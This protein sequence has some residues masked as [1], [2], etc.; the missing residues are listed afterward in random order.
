M[1]RSE[2]PDRRREP[3]RF[4]SFRLIGSTKGLA[5]VL[6]V[7]V[8]LVLISGGFALFAHAALW[9]PLTIGGLAG[10]LFLDL[11]YFNP[12]FVFIGVVNAAFLWALVWAHWRRAEWGLE[13]KP[14]AGEGDSHVAEKLRGAHPTG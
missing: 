12:W 4:V 8:A 10:S 1:G 2:A 7:V 6:A 3:V 14:D 9:R 13:V 5:A 11:L